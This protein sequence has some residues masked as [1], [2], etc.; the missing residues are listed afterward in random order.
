MLDGKQHEEV[1][2]RLK[3]ISGQVN[4]LARMIEDGRYCIDVLVQIAA[5]EAALHKLSALILQDHLETC[6]AESF[7]S[8]DLRDR[9]A[10]VEELV[11]VF[12]AMR[13]R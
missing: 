3:R 4:G 8:R 13:P 6:V 9:K 12:A 10:K 2:Q 7:N 11:R 5:V 1:R